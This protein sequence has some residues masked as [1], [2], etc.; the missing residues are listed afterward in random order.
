MAAE[1]E[2]EV[3]TAVGVVLTAIAKFSLT[4]GPFRFASG[5]ALFF[6]NDVVSSYAA[7]PYLVATPL[8]STC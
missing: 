2:A 4:K 5:R 7:F 3:L 8:L 6:A 1:V